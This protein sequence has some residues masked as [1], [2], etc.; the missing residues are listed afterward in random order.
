MVTLALS[1]DQNAGQSQVC[2]LV[3]C[4]T[5]LTNDESEIKGKQRVLSELKEDVS[6]KLKSQLLPLEAEASI[7]SSSNR[8]K[9]I[10]RMLARLSALSKVMDAASKVRYQLLSCGSL[11][12]NGF[13]FV[14]VHPLI[15]SSWTTVTQLHE[16]GYFHV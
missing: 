13:S 1:S 9:S 12:T 2:S 15:D 3:V 11:I 16:V 6:S 5:S 14:Q 10:N 4:L 8:P 7:S